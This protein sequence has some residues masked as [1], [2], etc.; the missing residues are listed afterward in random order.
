[1]KALAILSLI[2]VTGCTTTSKMDI[3]DLSHFKIDCSRK[4]EQL[5]FL[6]RQFSSQQDKF[7]NAFRVTSIVGTAASMH[8]GTYT[9]ERAMYEN[10]H[11]AVAR[12]LI[13][14]IK[15]S[16]HTETKRPQ[17]CVHLNEELPSGSAQGAVCYQN[18]QSTAVV[19]RWAV[20][21]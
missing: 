4:E 7:V 16:C 3:A 9:E 14:K 12:N 11:S 2:A 20:I 6:E 19:K 1:M 13:F 15:S 10:Y 18:R 8:D 21:D 5:A 17:G